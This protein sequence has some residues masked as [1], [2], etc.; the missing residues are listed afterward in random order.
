MASIERRTVGG[1]R[2]LF[3]S[4]SVL[5][6]GLMATAVLASLPPIILL[7]VGQ[8]QIAGLMGGAVKE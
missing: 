3:V 7:P 1:H 5:A 8:R 4:P 2:V 6:L